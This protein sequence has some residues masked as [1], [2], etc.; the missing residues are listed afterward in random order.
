MDN[1][2]LDP[3][4]ADVITHMSNLEEIEF[5]ASLSLRQHLPDLSEQIVNGSMKLDVA[6]NAL[7]CDCRM[8]WLLRLLRDEFGSGARSRVRHVHATCDAASGEGLSGRLL[9]EIAANHSAA[10]LFR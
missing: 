9:E 7:R 5:D 3:F 8:Q 4:S 2:N 6:N 10:V 1:T